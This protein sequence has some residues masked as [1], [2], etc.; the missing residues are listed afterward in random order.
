MIN[1]IIDDKN[2]KIILTKI[3]D[4]AKDLSRPMRKNS[5]YA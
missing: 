5:Q 4:N 3:G 1:V 2:A